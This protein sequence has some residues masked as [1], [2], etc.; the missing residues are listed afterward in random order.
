MSLL[1]LFETLKNEGFSEKIALAVC[2]SDAIHRS[3]K[4]KNEELLPENRGKY[5]LRVLEKIEGYLSTKN[6]SL[7]E[8]KQVVDLWSCIYS[9]EIGRDMN[10][11]GGCVYKTFKELLKTET[12]KEKT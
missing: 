8:T 9:W 10:G 7:E 1:N 5:R 6:Y 11:I 12:E 4:P 2:T 3:T